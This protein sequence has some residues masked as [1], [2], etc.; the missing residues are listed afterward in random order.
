[1]SVT[2]ASAA[3]GASVN[4]KADDGWALPARFPAGNR[5]RTA[6]FYFWQEQ[7]KVPA[8]RSP[9]KCLAAELLI[10]PIRPFNR[11]YAKS[12]KQT[13]ARSPSRSPDVDDDSFHWPLSGRAF[14]VARSRDSICREAGEKCDTMFFFFFFLFSIRIFCFSIAPPSVRSQSLSWR[15]L[16]GPRDR[17]CGTVRHASK[18]ET[19]MT[20][21]FFGSSFFNISRESLSISVCVEISGDRG[22]SKLSVERSARSLRVRRAQR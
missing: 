20:M 2:A 15:R 11:R 17:R 14:H 21:F 16:K 12:E 5:A 9:L 10:V 13:D 3:P 22:R 4:R 18:P 6:I 1:M 8:A 7:E 19:R